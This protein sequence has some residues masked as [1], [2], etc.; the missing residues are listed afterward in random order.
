MYFGDYLLEKKILNS[1]QL[2]KALCY[3]LENLPSMIR[4]V[5]ESNVVSSSEMFNLIKKQI[6]DDSD[7][8]TI[9]KNEKKS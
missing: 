1:D 6:N 2:L 5:W 8:L 9:L 7:I 4:I 3:Q